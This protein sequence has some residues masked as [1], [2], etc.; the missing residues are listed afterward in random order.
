M[1]N[2]DIVPPSEPAGYPAHDHLAYACR[3]SGD[4][5]E[6]E[7]ESVADHALRIG[8]KGHFS[9]DGFLHRQNCEA[10]QN[11]ALICALAAAFGVAAVLPGH[12]TARGQ[13]IN[14]CRAAV[15]VESRSKKWHGPTGPW[16]HV[17][18]W[19]WR[20]CA[21]SLAGTL[22]TVAQ[23]QRERRGRGHHR[24]DP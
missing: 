8:L 2:A 10:G 20:C 13:A 18:N 15:P 17:W 22:V 11:Q 3:R 14:A 5:F 6:R 4:R 7:A 19:H 23:G 16:Q 9:S 1:S 24:A 12:G 21:W